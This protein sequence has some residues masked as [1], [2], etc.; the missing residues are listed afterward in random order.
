MIPPKALLGRTVSVHPCVDRFGVPRFAVRTALYSPVAAHVRGFELRDARLVAR[1]GGRGT[2]AFYV[3]TLAS[4][5]PLASVRDLS[6]VV[7]SPD[8]EGFVLEADGS[9]PIAWSPRVAGA[10]G[11]TYALVRPSR[12]PRGVPACGGE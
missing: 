10:G 4:V 1:P 5:A 6:P 2:V 11:R 8:G 3:G 9:V 12:T 7:P